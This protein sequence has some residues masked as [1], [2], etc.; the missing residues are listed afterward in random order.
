MAQLDEAERDV[1]FEFESCCYHGN[2]A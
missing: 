1:M 2:Q